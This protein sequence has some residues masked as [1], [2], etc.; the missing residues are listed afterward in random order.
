MNHRKHHLIRH[1][2]RNNGIPFSIKPDGYNNMVQLQK[3]ELMCKIHL[4][5]HYKQLKIPNL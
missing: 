5:T 4:L 3:E 1:D 2:F